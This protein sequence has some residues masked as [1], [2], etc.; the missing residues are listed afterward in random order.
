MA[1]GLMDPVV[2][3]IRATESRDALAALGYAI[4]WHTYPMPHSVSPQEVQDLNAWLV[5]VLG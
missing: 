5:K 4:E 2:P 1:H 3:L